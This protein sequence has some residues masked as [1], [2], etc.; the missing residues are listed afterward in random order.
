MITKERVAQALAKLA[1]RGF[2]AAD[3]AFLVTASETQ[4]AALEALAAEPTV[5]EV[6]KVVEKVVEKP[7]AAAA[8]K[9]VDEALA[10]MPEGI[11]ESVKAGM[12]VAENKKTATIAALK[13]SGRCDLTDD[14]MKAMSQSQLDQLAKLGQVTVAAAVD[15][16]GQ[17][18]PRAQASDSKEAPAPPD[19]A[20]A[21]KANQGRK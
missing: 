11:R 6:E 8:P 3:E 15:Y 16:S 9:T 21:I 12:A 19:M 7:V 10:L 17:G 18:A 5:R 1:G 13:A 4:I 20:A 14:A 2:T